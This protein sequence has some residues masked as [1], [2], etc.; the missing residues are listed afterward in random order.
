MRIVTIVFLF[1]FFAGTSYCQSIDMKYY[2]PEDSFDPNIPTPEEVIGFIPGEWHASHDKLIMYYRALAE[3][4][5]KVS[6]EEY[7]YSYEGRPF[8]ASYDYC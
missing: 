1:T 6:L 7:A 3:A 8:N 5:E 4:S 2:F